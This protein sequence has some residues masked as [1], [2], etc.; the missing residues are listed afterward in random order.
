MIVLTKYAHVPPR[1]QQQHV[2]CAGVCNLSCNVAQVKTDP[3]A[4]VVYIHIQTLSLIF[5]PIDLM[6]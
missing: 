6:K 3:R 1:Q 5:H 2:K 4:T